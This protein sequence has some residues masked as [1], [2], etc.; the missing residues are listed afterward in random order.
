MSDLRFGVPFAEQLAFFRKK[1]NLP[2]AAWDDIMRSAHDRAFIVAG[3]MQADLLTDLRSAVDSA[4][5]NGEGLRAFQQRFDGIVAKH[6]WEHTG[7]R[8]WRSRVIYQTNLRTSY[9]AGRYRQLSDPDVLKRLPYWRYAHC[10]AVTHPRPQHLAWNNLI[11]RADDP[12]W[13]VHYPPNGWGCQ[14]RVFSAGDADLPAYGK[15][16]PDAAPND[17]SYDYVDARTGEVHT[18][19]AGIDYGWDYAPGSAALG[20]LLLDKAAVT[21][22]RI[23]AAAV[24]RALEH[25]D[26][27]RQIG[28]GFR[29]W[30]ERLQR[31]M[32]N[33][34][35]L[36]ALMPELL[37][38]LEGRGVALDTAVISLGD[39]QALH[40]LRDAKV[41]RG[42]NIPKELFMK[43]PDLLQRPLAVLWDKQGLAEGKRP[44]LLYVASA[45]GTGKMLKVVV[46][47]GYVA[48][49]VVAGKKGK[50]TLNAIAT[51]GLVNA[52][53]VA[54][55]V[56]FELLMGGW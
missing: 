31:P 28:A 53:D 2:S 8:N 56:A 1:L 43:L 49:E 15:A 52:E 32:G 39:Q 26:V 24:Q 35:N 16:A 14:C 45:P 42:A 40:M 7:S 27:A 48:K 30:A 12:W 36:G 54:D 4:I 50:F 46:D 11:L 38:E 21:V 20:A 18:L 3:A 44:A 51:A 37:A 19:P 17:G 25:T 22:P 47:L 34:I 41:G 5:A 6:G 10:D 33:R 55:T 9:A 29:L 23:G 13:D